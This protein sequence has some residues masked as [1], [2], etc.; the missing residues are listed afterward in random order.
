MH[1]LF[2]AFVFLAYSLSAKE[3]LEIS[4]LSPHGL[5]MN[6]ETG[7]ILFEKRAY[8]PVYPASTTKIAT[9]LYVLKHA[10]D[11][12]EDI[13]ISSHE[14]LK[15]A[16]E[17][18]KKRLKLPSYTL[19]SDGSSID[20]QSHEAIVLTD[21]LRGALISSGNDACNVLAEHL[22]GDIPTFVTKVNDMALSLGCLT[23]H[24]TNPHGLFDEEHITSAYDMALLTKEAL[25]YPLFREMIRSTSFYRP[26][27]NLQGKTVYPQTNQLLQPES[28]YYYPKAIGVK[29]GYTR[30]AKHNL[31][32]AA[33]NG[34]RFLI[35]VLHQSPS[36]PARYED[37]LRLFE[38]GFSEKKKERLL[39]KQ[40]ETSFLKKLP[41]TNYPLKAEL[42]EDVF[43]SFYPSEEPVIHVELVWEPPSFPIEKD[44]PVGSL[45]VLNEKNQK[46]LRATLHAQES[47]QKL[48]SYRLSEDIIPLLWR[49]P[50]P[51]VVLLTLFL[52]LWFYRRKN[53]KL[54]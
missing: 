47:V 3:S 13:C 16:S 19:E 42:K 50:I 17:Q 51:S 21:L 12:L 14:S 18:T 29:T 49:S 34:E 39:F 27:T 11:H 7:S 4:I 23:T 2:F 48:W 1:T 31:I 15:T 20:L 35:A 24:F 44:A 38:A 5:L 10:S 25:Q 46:I 9:V 26:Q 40:E 45:L 32:A 36:S 53:L 43:I 54:T 52:G 37:A 41:K 28:K 22:A 33:T 30:L 8:D 6:A